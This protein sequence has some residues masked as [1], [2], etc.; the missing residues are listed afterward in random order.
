LYSNV[1][2]LI[3]SGAFLLHVL[4]SNKAAIETF[5]QALIDAIYWL[6]T[7]YQLEGTQCASNLLKNLGLAYIDLL[8]CKSLG[9]EKYLSGPSED[10]FDTFDTLPSWPSNNNGED[11]WKQ[12]AMEQFTKYWGLYLQ[13]PD[14]KGD[15]QYATIKNAHSATL[16]TLEQL[17]NNKK[18]NKK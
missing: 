6:E 15:P 17:G 4:H 10:I 3:E 13:R 14:A 1:Y 9:Q 2:Y 12:W 5:P 8:Q 16:K 11:A 18:K 7:A